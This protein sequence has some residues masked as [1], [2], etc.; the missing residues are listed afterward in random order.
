MFNLRSSLRDSLLLTL[1]ELLHLLANFLVWIHLLDWLSDASA[2]LDCV[3][4]GCVDLML[5]RFD[6]KE[7]VTE[8]VG[9][10]PDRLYRDLMQLVSFLLAI[11]WVFGF[12]RS[13]RLS[14]RVL[15]G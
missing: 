8:E 11:E 10:A 2:I 12:G 14:L 9:S 5:E 1:F 7:R 6:H 13:S 3:R 4:Y 15:R